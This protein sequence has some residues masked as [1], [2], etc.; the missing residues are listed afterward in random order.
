MAPPSAGSLAG[1][2]ASNLDPLAENELFAVDPDLYSYLKES[3]A[4]MDPTLSG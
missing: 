2:D 1:Y 3:N 4:V